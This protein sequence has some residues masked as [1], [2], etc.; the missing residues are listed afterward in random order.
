MVLRADNH[1]EIR[2]LN[3]DNLHDVPALRTTFSGWGPRL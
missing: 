1:F 2:C 3:R